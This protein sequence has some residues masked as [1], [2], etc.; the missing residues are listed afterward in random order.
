MATRSSRPLLWRTRRLPTEGSNGGSDH[1]AGFLGRKGW[2]TPKEPKGGTDQAPAT[3]LP[4]SPGP[5]T[6]Q[7]PDSP[8][9]EVAP[10]A[11]AWKPSWHMERAPTRRASFHRR[12]TGGTLQQQSE[13]KAAPP[14]SWCSP[15]TWVSGQPTSRSYGS[16]DRWPLR[17]LSSDQ[18]HTKG[19][20]RACQCPRR[21]KGQPFW[22]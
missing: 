22:T 19:W 10:S 14:A 1:G 5:R 16:A 15:P 21:L 6:G 20:K 7:L 13:P 12:D 8:K 11:M 18:P 3:L 4:T 2:K 9:G 17:L